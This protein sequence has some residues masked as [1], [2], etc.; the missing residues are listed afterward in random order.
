MSILIVLAHK[1]FKELIY[2]K[3]RYD[4]L[5]SVTTFVCNGYIRGVSLANFALMKTSK[6]QSKHRHK[7]NFALAV[8]QRTATLTPDILSSRLLTTLKNTLI[9]VYTCMC[10]TCSDFAFVFPYIQNTSHRIFVLDVSVF[11]AQYYI[12]QVCFETIASRVILCSD[13]KNNLHFQC[14]HASLLGLLEWKVL[15]RICLDHC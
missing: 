13:Y 5:T 6:I 3:G 1:T 14:L 15:P 2:N 7:I 10:N 12:C 11:I 9:V 4:S 8:Y